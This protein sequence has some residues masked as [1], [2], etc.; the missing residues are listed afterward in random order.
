VYQRN[1][2]FTVEENMKLSS[3]RF[4]TNGLFGQTYGLANFFFAAGVIVG[5]IWAGFVNQQ[6]SWGVVA[7][8]LGLVS[9]LS[10]IPTALFTGDNTE[11]R[12]RAR[13]VRRRRRRLAHI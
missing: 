1:N 6:A 3:H 13:G 8:S 10:A 11:E 12:D 9:A 7:R 5:P 2:T 4:G